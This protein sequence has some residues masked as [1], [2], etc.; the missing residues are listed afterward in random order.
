MGYKNNRETLLLRMQHGEEKMLEKYEQ[1][2]E[3]ESFLESWYE[4]ALVMNR[5]FQLLARLS[6]EALEDSPIIFRLYV[7]FFFY[8][9]KILRVIG[10][11][12]I[13]YWLFIR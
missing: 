2:N 13:F 8:A 1:L 12:A 6:I 3:N 9:S 11:I 4:T 7:N 5:K 10:L